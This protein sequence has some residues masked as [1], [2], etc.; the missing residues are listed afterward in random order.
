MALIRKKS[1]VSSGI[2]TAAMA[3]I[4]FL[5][6]IFFLVTTVFEEAK[7]LP[8]VLPEPEATV[9]VEPGDLL[10]I[11][12]RP[13]GAIEVRLGDEPSGRVVQPSEIAAVWRAEAAR[14]ARL[15]AAV[16]T[17]PATPYRFMIDVLDELQGAGAERISLEL[18]EK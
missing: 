5:L 2:P 3:D 11:V 10:H 12:I 4:A 16:R 6:L 7:G 13:D 15:V 8:I 9:T 18:L 14:N 17:D 1:R